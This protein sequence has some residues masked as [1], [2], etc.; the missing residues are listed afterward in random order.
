MQ[1]KQVVA[2]I[3]LAF[4]HTGQLLRKINGPLVT[5]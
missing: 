1:G 2:K 5:S 4:T 3:G